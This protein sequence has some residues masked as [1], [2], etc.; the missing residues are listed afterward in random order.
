MPMAKLDDIVI[1]AVAQR[2]LE[3]E[4]L[5]E[6][7]HEYLKTAQ[8]RDDKQRDQLKY[9]R[10]AH[11]DAE[12]GLTRLMDL[13]ERGLMD[14]SDP[15]LRERIVAT[16]FRRDELASE[17]T[18]LSQRLANA[19]PI[20]TTD[21]VRRLG[22]LL[23]KQLHR[24]LPDLRQAYTRLLLSEVLVNGSNIT[25]TGSKAVLARTA[26]TEPEGSAPEVLSCRANLAMTSKNQSLQ[27][28]SFPD[29]L[30][31]PR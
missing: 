11:S 31:Y 10:S 20:I 13:V 14:V 28:V 30:T 5:E 17:I 6:L 21:K 27:W 2:I 7:L 18:A 22:I 9:L 16:R 12:A 19:D 15:A 1:D 23:S 29:N 8:S 25:I 26:S 4:R 24:G 3:P